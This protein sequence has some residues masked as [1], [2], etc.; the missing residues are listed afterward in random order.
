MMAASQ[1]TAAKSNSFRSPKMDD[2][3]GPPQSKHLSWTSEQWPSFWRRSWE[4]AEKWKPPRGPV[5][6]L[7]PLRWASDLGRWLDS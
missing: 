6:A 1:G 4:A 3:E 2:Q 5:R 7:H